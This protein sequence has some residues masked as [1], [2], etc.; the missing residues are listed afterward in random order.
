METVE[1]VI[2]SITYLGDKQPDSSTKRE[3]ERVKVK[4]DYFLM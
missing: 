1:K 2:G 4:S 3:R